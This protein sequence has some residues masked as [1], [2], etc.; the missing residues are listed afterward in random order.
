MFEVLKNGKEL[1]ID[2]L[3]KRLNTEYFRI[4]NELPILIKLILRSSHTYYRRKKEDKKILVLNTCLIG[5][6]VVALP[7]LKDFLSETEGVVDM[8]VIPPVESL[9]KRIRGI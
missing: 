5:D 1:T 9:A 3:D 7:A 8:V 4:L 6:F 2:L